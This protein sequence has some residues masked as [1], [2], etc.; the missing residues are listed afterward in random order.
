MLNIFDKKN[1]DYFSNTQPPTFPDGLDVEFL[2][3][4]L[5]RLHK[6]AKSKY[7]KNMLPHLCIKT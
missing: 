6:L 4:K 7:D 5:K 2:H 3:S 1:V